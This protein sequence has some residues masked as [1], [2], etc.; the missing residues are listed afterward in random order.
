[1]FIHGF[2]WVFQVFSVPVEERRF[3]EMSEMQFGEKGKVQ[4]RICN[5]IMNKTGLSIVFVYLTLFVRA[6]CRRAGF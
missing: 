2:V 3:K 1:M 4:A 5:D 6:T